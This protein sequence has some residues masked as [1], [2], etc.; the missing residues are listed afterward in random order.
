MLRYSVIALLLQLSRGQSDDWGWDSPFSG[1][2]VTQPY[3]NEGSG[4]SEPEPEPESESEPEPES[5]NQGVQ[6][7]IPRIVGLTQ[8][9]P[10][11]PPAAWEV[12]KKLYTQG[13]PM[14]KS[15]ETS[16]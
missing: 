5:S 16:S 13:T 3:P 12:I 11:P 9:I 7:P 2:V 6:W 14:D 15:L 1:E 8:T 10:N 4:E